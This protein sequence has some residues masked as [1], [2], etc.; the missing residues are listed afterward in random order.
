MP[1]AAKFRL[2]EYT[3]FDIYCQ[4]QDIAFHKRSQHFFCFALALAIAIRLFR[5]ELRVTQILILLKHLVTELGHWLKLLNIIAISLTLLCP[6]IWCLGFIPSMAISHIPQGVF[7]QT[8]NLIRIGPRIFATPSRCPGYN[9]LGN[10]SEHSR[11]DP[12][13]MSTPDRDIY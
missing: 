12:S 8:I 7:C 9:P 10:H 1:K 2:A 11:S 3:R 13:D 5:Y 6:L 4:V